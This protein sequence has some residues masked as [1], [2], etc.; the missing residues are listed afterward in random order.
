MADLGNQ[1]IKDTYQL[2]LQT[3]SSGNLQKLDGSTPNPFIVNGNLRYLDGT[4]HPSGYV[5]ISDGSGNA[6]WGAVA[7]SGDVYISGGSIDDTVITL[8]T[9]SGNTISIPGLAWSAGTDGSVSPSGATTDVR[10]SGNTYSNNIVL[11]SNAGGTNF[12]QITPD[13]NHGTIKFMTKPPGTADN[14]ES[15]IISQD[16]IEAKASPNT[17]TLVS[18]MKLQPVDGGQD[19]I[20]FNDAN[21]DIDFAIKSDN[22]IAFKL[23]AANDMMAFRD[24]VGIGYSADKWPTSTGGLGGTPTYQLRVAGQTLLSGITTPLEV[25]GNI[26]GTT[27]LYL[28]DTTNTASTITAPNKLTIKGA[29]TTNDFLTLEDDYVQVF[30]D[31]ASA[32]WLANTPGD[33][34][35]I[36]NASSKDMNTKIL[37]NDQTNAVLVDAGLNLVRLHEHVSI[38]PTGADISDYSRTL[39]VSGETQ[40]EGNVEVSGST[41][42]TGNTFY[43]GALSGTGSINTTKNLYVSGNTFIG[44]TKI[45]VEDGLKIQTS[46]QEY[47]YIY[48]NGDTLEMVSDQ[49]DTILLGDNVSVNSSLLVADNI[50]HKDDVTNEISFASATQDFRTNNSSRLD[51]SNSGVRLG[52]ANSRV[53]TILDEDNM[54]SD[55]NTSLATQQSIKAYVDS[56]VAGSDTLQEVTDN[57][58]TTTNAIQ[59]G[60]NLGISGST[61]YEGTLSGTGSITTMSSVKG[62]HFQ[63]TDDMSVP[64]GGK[65]IL[66]DVGGDTYITNGGTNNNV[67]LHAS[68]NLLLTVNPTIGLFT[69]GLPISGTNITAT[70]YI[71]VSGDIIHT[72]DEDNKISF[73]TDTQD[74][75]TGGSSRLDI[76]DSGVRL[77]GA[78]S[79]VTT[80]LDEDNL[81]TNS[82]TALATQQS[83]KAYVDSQVATS[84]TLQE[85]TD[86][87]STTTNAIQ[88]GSNLG[89]SGDTFYEGALSG[90]GN[91]TTTA[92]I[93][94]TGNLTT[95]GGIR[96][97][98]DDFVVDVTNTPY[99]Q[100]GVNTNV[101]DANL[102]ISGNTGFT[103]YDMNGGTAQFSE[104]FTRVLFASGADTNG[105]EV[106]DT[107]VVTDGGGEDRIVTVATI[108]DSANIFLDVAFPG[109][110]NTVNGF[111]YNGLEPTPLRVYNQTTLA[112]EVDGDNTFYGGALSGT[113]NITTT[114]N[115]FVTGDTFYEGALSGT[116]SITTTEDIGGTNITASNNLYVSGNTYFANS[117]SANDG[118]LNFG[119]SDDLT[120]YHDGSN[121][122]IHDSGTG[123]LNIKGGAGVNII[124][125]ADENMATFEGNGAVNLYYNNNLKFE[126]TDTGVLVTGDIKGTTLTSTSNLYIT[127]NTF[128]EGALS[129]TGDIQISDAGKFKI[130]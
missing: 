17:G 81:G 77:G 109:A 43:E 112:L 54:A 92:N 38:T 8:Q 40:F 9:T 2:V 85:V 50:Q 90:T 33:G 123:R 16:L 39:F 29:S 84:D 32:L 108:S 126:T 100:V 22:Q 91:I 98:I 15:L 14:G 18:Y 4:S 79:R 51:I 129:G 82:D 76:S 62:E 45:D 125:P 12:G 20:S 118:R 19:I 75:Q 72:G 52:G 6:S 23:D 5:L 116:G 57:G 122:Y 127:G 36:L 28:G 114:G 104:G 3:D 34:Q 105:L 87:G 64:D 25:I 71:D 124:S 59:L 107:L 60:S 110:S 89:I 113:G 78:N 27:D 68:N 102:T 55:S 48:F 97:N 11:K 61:F 66:D 74:Y 83:I 103:A 96:T 46:G 111:T 121:S 63:S 30:I 117:T 65:Y 44:G 47:P 53:T 24:Y 35:I 95:T 70:G 99:K 37:T 115:L 26:S 69:N 130:R 21:N 49:G 10:I 101:P 120:I 13:V 86:N 56:Q 41:Y 73:G 31:G 94:A 119:A 128:Y 1:K 80:I 88:L 106:G 58:A 67:E 93:T 42:I 7:F